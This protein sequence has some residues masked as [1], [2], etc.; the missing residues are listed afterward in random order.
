MEQTELIN[1]SEIMEEERERRIEGD[2]P[3]VVDKKEAQLIKVENNA[4]APKDH[5]Q[6]S[7]VAQQYL[8]SGAL[9]DCFKNTAQVITG[10]Q[11]A[12]EKG[13]DPLSSLMNTAIIGGK[14][15]YHSDKPLQMVIESGH[16]AGMK[17]KQFDKDYNLI[18]IENKNLDAKAEY[19]TCWV[20][21]D[22]NIERECYFT[23]NM[24]KEAGLIP[25]NSL[26]PWAKYPK[27][28]LQMR[29]RS[30]ALK[31]VFPDALEGVKIA[32]YDFHEMPGKETQKTR[33]V[34]NSI[35]E[36]QFDVKEENDKV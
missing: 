16:L 30:L 14:F 15:T 35:E 6:V 28:M 33:E 22:N 4:M 23:M 10:M 20:K 31:D 36:I 21:R 29:A 8:Q 11:L 27:R 26:K 3:L 12:A 24:A 5:T 19:A 25:C 32:E 7:R 9:P 2:K 18:C 1:D 13:Q 34:N 17:E